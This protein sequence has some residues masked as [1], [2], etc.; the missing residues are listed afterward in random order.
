MLGFK[1]YNYG[2]FTREVLHDPGEASFAGPEPGAKAPDFKARALDGETV[3]LSDYEGKKNVLLVFGSATCPM[4]AGSI[5]GINE[6]YNEFRGDEI[7]FLFV[8]VREAHP[9]EKVP[10]HRSL[11]D[12]IRAARLLRDEEEI[13]MPVVVDDLRG[14]IHRKYSRLPNPA[15]LID[16]SGRVAFRS[17]WAKPAELGEAI[18]ELLKLQAERGVDHVVV[19]G[20]QDLSM[21]VSYGVLFSYRALERGGE[22]ALN[23]FREVFGVPGRVVITTSRVASPILENPGRVL[24]IITLTGAVLAGGLYAGF[25]LRKRR[26]GARRNPYRAYEDEEVRDT[27]TGTDY[28]AVGI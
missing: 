22:Q 9:G 23:D 12:K 25:E 8:Y 6:L 15:F 13:Q 5:R 21:P 14:S 27:D 19:G 16:K 1:D 18:E 28:G 17:M 11:S 10:A 26:L 7:E 24:A 4:T 3:C 2:H 20:G